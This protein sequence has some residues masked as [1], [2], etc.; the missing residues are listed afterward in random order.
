MATDLKF[1]IRYVPWLLLLLGIDI[2]A[3]LLLW[4]A[5][6]QAFS[7]MA[8]V[9]LLFTVVL[10]AALCCVLVR[11]EQ[12]REQAFLDFLNS[13]DEHHEELLRKAVSLPQRGH[14]LSLGRILREKE[15]AYTGLLEQWNDHEEYVEAWA[16]EIKIPL[17][18][19][20]LLLDNRREELPGPIAFKL[21]HIRNRMQESIDQILFYARLKSARKDYL[22]EHVCISECMEEVLEDYRPLL[23][24]KG[25]TLQCLLS[26]ETVYTDRRGLRFLLGQIISNSI[27]YCSRDP[28]LCL[29][30]FQQDHRH[31][32]SVRD[33]GNGV[34]SCDL[35]YI[36]EKGF[37]GDS[38]ENRKKATGMGL[39]LAKEI[40]RDLNLTL[41]VSSRWGQGFEMQISFPVVEER[42][43]ANTL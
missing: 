43:L 26:H 16:H 6:V 36:F 37:T 23:E 27:K 17:S 31:I 2:F 28:E 33:N 7:A 41:H 1:L 13:P 9:I 22:F 21:D 10:F 24:E 42:H 40:A 12:K 25:F 3:S 32:L 11:L 19:L 35:P 29:R 5:D 15:N 4:L 38:G 39:Y 34:R 18:L 8:T 30:S 20:T 14:I